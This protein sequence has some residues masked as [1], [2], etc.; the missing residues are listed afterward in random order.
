MPA[1]WTLWTPAFAK[2]PETGLPTVAGRYEERDELDDVPRQRVSGE[3]LVCGVGF[4]TTCD[5]GQP[6]RHIQSFAVVHQQLH[7]RKYSA[8]TP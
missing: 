2:H 1:E 7:F 6:R 8:R 4:Q 3:C 5:S